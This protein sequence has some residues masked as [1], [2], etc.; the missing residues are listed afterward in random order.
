M[1]Q[2]KILFVYYQNIKQNGISNSIANVSKELV[3]KGFEVT[4]L[5]LMREHE[6]FFVIDQRVKKIYLDS[7]DTTSYKIAGKL[8]EKSLLKGKLKN[9]VYY[10]YDLGCFFVL[11]NWIR[12]NHQNYEE[13]ITCWYKLSTY[14]TFTKASSK[15]TAWE[16]INHK[17]GGFLFFSLLRK[18]YKKLKKVICL[19]N[20]ALD[21]YQTS[22]ISVVKI[23]NVINEKYENE[24]FDFDKKE[25]TILLASRLDPEK[26]VKGF[27]E[28]ISD[29]NLPAKWN[30]VVAGDGGEFDF[31]QGYARD[32]GIK[33]IKFLGAVA[34][35]QMID[36]F[37]KSEIYCMTSLV[38]GLPTTLI[39]AMFCGNALISYDCPTGPSEII[40]ENNG[41]LVPLHD[42]ENFKEKLNLLL[43]HPSLLKELSHNSYQESAKWR[44][45][46]IMRQWM[47]L[48]AYD[49]GF[50]KTK[51]PEKLTSYAE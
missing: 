4:I 27:L 38:E 51:L 26:N 50:P 17:T 20:E 25:N 22:G 9:V 37:R 14:L 18:R 40:N 6:D 34:S 19:T 48:L 43:N 24:K 31:L 16:H 44:R 36:L 10:A 30:I 2:K 11:K 49:D 13:I 7:F 3:N 39:E 28:I 33:R 29:I 41:F 1:T 35:G 46:I 23:A 45:E 32:L 5:F 47:S 12:H 8:R 21:Y 42:K 15:T